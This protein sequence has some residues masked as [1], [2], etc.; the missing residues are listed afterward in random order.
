[1]TIINGVEIGNLRYLSNDIKDAVKN[2]LPL[3]ETLHVVITIS[4][5][6][7]YA[8]RYIL[9]KEFVKRIE[10]EETNV[11]LYVVEVAYDIPGQDIPGQETQGFHVTSCKNPRHLQLRAKVP[12][13]HKESGIDVGIKKLLPPDWKAVA[14]IDADIE[15]D[16]P[17]W[18]RDT[19]KILNGS[20]DVVQL[21]SHAIDL[22]IHGD[23]MN[24][25]A[26]FGYQY[27]YQRKYNHGGHAHRSYHPGF[28]WACTRKFYDQIGSLYDL[29][30]LGSGDF[31]MALSMLGHG[32]KSL[33]EYVS[34]GYKRSILEFQE[35]AGEPKIGYVPGVIRHNFHGCKKNRRYSTRWMILVKHQYDPYVHVTKNKDG[36]II[37][38]EQCPKHLLD[39]IFDYFR[40]RNEDEL[41]EQQMEKLSVAH[42]M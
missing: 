40:Q 6:C 12:L 24:I 33:S 15:F 18:A 14:W 1:M 35:K 23:A 39:D 27:T 31:N 17:S 21:F 4:N 34:E 32:V 19:L 41:F 10:M 38:T 20:R 29:S 26:S 2:N 16:S 28:G 30:I 13:W 37:P 11:K 8:R 9:A 25:F 7:Q 22:D 36:L 42:G 3:E 5:C